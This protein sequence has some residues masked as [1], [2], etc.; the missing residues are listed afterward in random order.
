MLPRKIDL[1]VSIT[2][3]DIEALIRAFWPYDGLARVAKAIESG[4][5]ASQ[6]AMAT[7]RAQGQV[8]LLL[9]IAEHVG[10]T[11]VLHSILSDLS[12]GDK[13]G[14]EGIDESIW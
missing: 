13:A 7:G 14:E 10:G 4:A 2:A 5:T 6:V 12:N 8:D 1:N 9:S 11:K 3:S